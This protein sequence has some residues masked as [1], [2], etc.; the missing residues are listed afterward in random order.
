M[1]EFTQPNAGEPDPR[2]ALVPII[3]LI[4]RAPTH[5]FG[6][7]P[8]DKAADAR[9]P[10]KS[11]YHGSLYP[12]GFLDHLTG[13]RESPVI[14]VR[15]R[16]PSP[17]NVFMYMRLRQDDP[18]KP[19]TWYVVRRPTAFEI[20]AL[21]RSRKPIKISSGFKEGEEV[22]A[23][24]FFVLQR[25]IQRNV[26]IARMMP[27]QVSVA[28]ML[29]SY[30]DHLETSIHKLS[31]NTVAAY[32][33][34]MSPLNAD[35]GH[36]KLGAI[37]ERRLQ[38]YVK[39]RRRQ[40]AANGGRHRRRKNPR[41]VSMALI[42][43]ELVLFRA[44][45]RR[46]GEKSGVQ[47]D[48][49]LPEFHVLRPPV[50][51]LTREQFV[52][53]LLALRGRIW[54]AETGD[55]RRRRDDDPSLTGP[56][57]ALLVLRPPETRRFRRMM[58]RLFYIGAYTG[59]RHSAMLAITHADASG[60]TIDW[61]RR[62][63]NRRGPHEPETHKRRPVV[64]LTPRLAEFFACWAKADAKKKIKYVIHNRAGE[65]Y[66]DIIGTQHW[67]PID[68]DA[69]LGMKVT[70]HVLR[71]TCAMWMKNEGIGLWDAANFLGCST[72]VI[73]FIYGTWDLHSQVK[74]V[75]ALGTMAA[76]RRATR[77]LRKRGL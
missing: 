50:T 6:F 29:H 5:G 45:V 73:E 44:I 77:E 16:E 32:T 31:E 39:R 40:S 36:E 70:P 14:M 55:W 15:P 26:I 59:T 56:E 67:R 17:K 33:S 18:A 10:R 24:A 8:A 34:Y 54:N 11:I 25:E 12:E 46:F 62:A 30:L 64:L 66:S 52:R 51:W 28:A 69:G 53:Y 68:K 76:Q 58:T 35:L 20:T 21:G 43:A 27:G 75:E 4:S 63:L 2:R 38:D 60:G 7:E 9:A 19:G 74:V 47:L 61:A 13:V 23:T 37:D 72:K 49:H 57:G 65:R 3:P 48:V 1:A 71:H 41:P 22:L 42:R